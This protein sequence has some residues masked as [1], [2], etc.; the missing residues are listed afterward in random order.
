MQSF[1]FEIV[2]TLVLMFVILSVSTGAK[3]KAI[4]AG[5]R[6]DPSSAWRRYSLGRF[7]AP[8]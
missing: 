3:E 5:M 7:P 1:I 6:L 4:T 8:P 2:L